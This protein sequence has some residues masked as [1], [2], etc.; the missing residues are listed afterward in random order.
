MAPIPD[1]QSSASVAARWIK[2]NIVAAIVAAVASL[3]VYGIR[4][5]TGAADA[6]ADLGARLVQYV[7]AIGFSGFSGAAMGV[8]TGAVLQRIIPALPARAWVI[9]HAAM[10]AVVALAAEVMTAFRSDA[11][12]TDASTDDFPIAA[13]MLTGAVLGASVGAI[14]AL[15]LRRAASGSAAWIAWSTVG[16]AVAV[17]LLAGGFRLWSPPEGGFAGELVNEIFDV[18]LGLIASVLLLPALRQLRPLAR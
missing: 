5:L 11:A 8:L 4:Q 14:E 18:V 3:A 16:F 12:A 15:V 7:A 6:E 1:T 2:A 10:G 9:L 13:W 17:A